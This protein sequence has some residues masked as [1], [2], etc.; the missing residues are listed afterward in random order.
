MD[1]NS[2]RSTMEWLHKKTQKN[3]LKEKPQPAEDSTE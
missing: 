1:I 2:L 3:I